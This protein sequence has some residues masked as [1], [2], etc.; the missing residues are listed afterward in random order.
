LI[1]RKA[2]NLLLFH[3]KASDRNIRQIERSSGWRIGKIGFDPKRV[4][5]LS[6]QYDGSHLHRD[7]LQ[8]PMIIKEECG[9]IK[10]VRE[11]DL[12]GWRSV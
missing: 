3:K 1:K 2:L 10:V 4:F 5:N 9:L 11:L 8:T 12:P 7:N 6:P